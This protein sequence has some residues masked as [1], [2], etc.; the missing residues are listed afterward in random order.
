MQ[1]VAKTESDFDAKAVSPKGAIGVMQLMPETAKALGADPSGR[2]ALRLI[3]SGRCN[4]PSYCC[5]P[6]RSALPAQT[7]LGAG[8]RRL[9]PR[10][11]SQGRPVMVVPTATVRGGCGRKTLVLYWR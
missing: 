2:A 3:Y 9:P 4:V 11:L 6:L 10:Y 1:N 8:V 5:L 7:S